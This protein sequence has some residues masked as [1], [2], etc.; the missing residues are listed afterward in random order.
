MS[1]IKKKLP[2]PVYTVTEIICDK[3]GKKQQADENGDFL[4][5]K[6]GRGEV[7]FGYGSIHDGRWNFDL[8]DKCFTKL[9]KGIAKDD[10][11]QVLK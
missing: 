11:G 6:M 10:M 2:R 1:Q 8:C 3:C 4:I 7:E 9:F 5:D